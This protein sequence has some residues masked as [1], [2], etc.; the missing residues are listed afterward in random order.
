MKVFVLSIASVGAIVALHA[1]PANAQ[2]VR[3]KATEGF[4]LESD[5]N[6]YFQGSP[7]ATNTKSAKRGTSSPTSDTLTSAK[8]AKAAL[9]PKAD[10]ESGS[11]SSPTSDTL[12][13]TSSPTSDTL[14]SKS[15][16]GV[17]GKSAKGIVKGESYIADLGEFGEVTLEAFEDEFCVDI[18]LKNI[19]SAYL[20]DGTLA[21]HL[22]SGRVAQTSSGIDE[23]DL[24]VV[25]TTLIPID[26]GSAQCG[27]AN[28][29][30]HFDPKCA[31]GPASSCRGEGELQA[32]SNIPCDAASKTDT[33]AYYTDEACNFEDGEVDGCEE[34]DSSGYAGKIKINKKGSGKLSFCRSYEDMGDEYL[35][36]EGEGDDQ[37]NS[38]T[39]FSYVLHG[40][41]GKRVLCANLLEVTGNIIP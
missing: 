5:A 33:D 36:I 22:H 9:F 19:P 40:P 14:G 7:P 31:C 20:N 15:S 41:G 23:D 27:L 1:A 10:K 13:S 6:S 25:G 37:G 28:T 39:W 30:G 24:R 16:K 17:F 2:Q 4:V 3:R 34:G 26:G 32:G 38:E 8:S 11:T 21:H 12:G 29:K 18:N 35:Q